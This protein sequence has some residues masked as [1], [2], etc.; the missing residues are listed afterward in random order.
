MYREDLGL[1]GRLPR[2]QIHPDNLWAL[3]GLLDKEAGALAVAVLGPLAAPAPAVDGIPDLRSSGARYAD[4]FAQLCQLATPKLPQVRGERPNVA[5]TMSWES[6]QATAAGSTGCA[7]G[8]LAA[9]IPISIEATRRVLC[10]ANVI[11]IVLGSHGEPLDV[12]R[13]TRTIP[14]AIRRALVARDQ[15]RPTASSMTSSCLQQAK[16]TSDRPASW[17]DAH[18]CTHWADGGPTAVCNLTLLCAHHHDVIHHDPRFKESSQHL[19]D[20]EV[21]RDEVTQTGTP[22]AGI[23]GFAA[24]AARVEARVLEVDRC[25]I[26]AGVGAAKQPSSQ[27]AKQPARVMTIE[28]AFA[29]CS[30]RCDATGATLRP[31]RRGSRAGTVHPD[32]ARRSQWCAVGA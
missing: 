16:R 3:R 9:G 15:G 8:T 10:D 12:G 4:A 24:G 17:C 7:P 11:P 27:A 23:V 31:Y 2:A 21:S 26:Y 6:L 28:M 20:R 22:E 30:H 1:G 25:G 19:T 29:A 5:L 18:H 13:A 14:T 32:I